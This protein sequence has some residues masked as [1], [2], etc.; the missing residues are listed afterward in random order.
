MFILSLTLHAIFVAY[1]LYIN[2]T[3]H[4]RLLFI[5]YIYIVCHFTLIA[6]TI[7]PVILPYYIWG[8]IYIT[9]R[10]ILA[11]LTTFLRHTQYYYAILL[12]LLPPPGMPSACCH[13]IRESHSMPYMPIAII[14]LLFNH[15]IAGGAFITRHATPLSRSVMP[16]NINIICCYMPRQPFVW[17]RAA[18]K[19]SSSRCCCSLHGN[20][21]T[22]ITLTL[23]YG[24]LHTPR[25]RRRHAA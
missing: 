7:T 19:P 5:I 2:Y 6:F 16:T 22:L 14:I 1:C 21:I 23:P 9:L 15:Y 10:L 4:A 24:A 20:I 17:R 3:Y 11:T 18:P 12:P 8:D 25:C 13:V